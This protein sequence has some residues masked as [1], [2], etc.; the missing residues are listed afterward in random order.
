MIL[1]AAQANLDS[2]REVSLYWRWIAIACLTPMTVGLLNGFYLGVLFGIHPALFWIADAL[3]FVGLTVFAVVVFATKLNL[4]PRDYGFV[5]PSPKYDWAQFVLLTLLIFGANALLYGLARG[6]ALRFFP[7]GGTSFDYTIA[8]APSGPLRLLGTLYL[9]F[10]AGFAEEII[11]RAI[12]WLVFRKLSNRPMLPYV[13]CTA[14]LFGLIHWEG[15][16]SSVISATA[17][18]VT[19]AWIYGRIGNIWPLVVSH[20]L[21]DYLVFR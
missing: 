2:D 10:T 11:F 13:I 12:P 14:I 7:I 17:I 18:G 1:G 15:G 4:R 20:A 5:P 3:H 16:P 9:C 21:I 6:F 8:L 19:F